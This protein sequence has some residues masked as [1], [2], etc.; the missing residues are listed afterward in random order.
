MTCQ[1]QIDITEVFTGGQGTKGK[2]KFSGHMRFFLDRG[3]LKTEIF[4]VSRVN[5]KQLK[6]TLGNDI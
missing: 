6:M 1:R 2:M 4:I 5:L 3:L